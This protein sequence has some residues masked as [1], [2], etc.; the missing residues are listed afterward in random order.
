MLNEPAT[1]PVLESWMVY[2]NGLP[3]QSAS[4]QRWYNA[5]RY[6]KIISL[7]FIICVPF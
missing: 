4:L 5:V 6:E 1:E 7:A 3:R 2:E